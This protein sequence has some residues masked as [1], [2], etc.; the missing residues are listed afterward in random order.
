MGRIV[1]DIQEVPDSISCV[2]EKIKELA[3]LIQWDPEPGALSDDVENGRIETTAVFCPRCGALPSTAAVQLT[4]QD[5]EP[6]TLHFWCLKRHA[7][8]WNHIEG[9]VVEPEKWQ[10]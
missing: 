6:I 7:W 8:R 5:G 9:R 1:A 10:L 2:L 4:Y 3:G